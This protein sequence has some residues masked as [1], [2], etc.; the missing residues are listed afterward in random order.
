[1]T[2]L[3]LQDFVHSLIGTKN[4]SKA[5]FKRALNRWTIAVDAEELYMKWDDHQVYFYCPDIVL[6][7]PLT[8]DKGDYHIYLNA[9]PDFTFQFEMIDEQLIENKEYKI[10]DFYE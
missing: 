1:M 3:T 9:S 7:F 5:E 10:I 2:K 6:S 8:K 4:N